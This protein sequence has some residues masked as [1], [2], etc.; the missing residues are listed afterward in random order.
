MTMQNK[1]IAF[2]ASLVLVFGQALNSALPTHA[3]QFGKDALGDPN[4]IDIRGS[5]GFLY[6]CLLYTSDAADE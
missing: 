6:S 1:A 4:A 2:V 5:S 3:V